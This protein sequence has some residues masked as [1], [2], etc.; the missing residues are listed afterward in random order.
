MASTAE[1]ANLRL[2]EAVLTQRQT[3]DLYLISN[4]G[5]CA[6][7]KFLMRRE[8]EVRSKAIELGPLPPDQASAPTPH[9][10]THRE[11]E[12]FNSNRPSAR[13]NSFEN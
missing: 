1:D 8:D 3:F 12:N 2:R 9:D 13:G 6:G 4:S 7:R 10:G 5:V 11:P